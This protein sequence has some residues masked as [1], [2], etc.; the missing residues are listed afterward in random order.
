MAPSGRHYRGVVRAEGLE[1]SRGLRPNGFSCQRRL[2]PPSR[3]RVRGTLR[4]VCGL[5]YT[6]TM[7]VRP[8][9]AARLVSTPSPPKSSVGDWLGIAISQGSPNLS[10]SASP[11]SRRALKL[12]LSP[13]R[14]PIP[15]RPRGHLKYK[16][17]VPVRNSFA[18]IPAALL[19]R[20]ILMAAASRL[21]VMFKAHYSSIISTDVLQ[22]LAIWQISASPSDASKCW[23][24]ANCKR[25]AVALRGRLSVAV[26]GPFSRAACG[27]CKPEL[28]C[29]SSF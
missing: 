28:T 26:R 5:D 13:M 20:M 11:V 25:C 17:Q 14:L 18:A 1:P 6:F 15:P 23:C 10:S 4:Q 19:L 2:S 24:G 3:G 16:P 9:G 12:R 27:F 7:A 21:V 29:Y 8:A 22:F